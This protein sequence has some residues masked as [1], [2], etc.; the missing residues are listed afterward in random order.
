MAAGIATLE[1]LAAPEVYARLEAR[2][3]ELADGL[4][5]AAAEAGV[6]VT[7]N[8][9]ASLMTVFFQAGPVTDYASA[10]RSDTRRFGVFFR[11]MLEGG[12]YLPPSQF[13]A[14]MVSTAFSDADLGRVLEV[15]RGAFAAAAAEA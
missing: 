6:A 3:A 1:L 7:V 8:R 13:E 9:V 11:A 12:V 10:L 15:A 14:A 2:A 5:S 4:R